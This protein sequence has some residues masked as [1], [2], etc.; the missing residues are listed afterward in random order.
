MVSSAV[1]PLLIAVCLVGC[2]SDASGDLGQAHEASMD[3][4]FKGCPPGIPSFEPGLQAKGN[5][6]AI[7]VLSAEPTEPQRYTNKWEVEL[8]ALDGAPAADA[9]IKKSQTF[10]PVHGHDG[11]VV[12]EVSALASAAQF[13]VDHL[14]FTMRGPWEVRFWLGGANVDEDYIVFHVC[15]AK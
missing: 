5:S 4:D 7:K 15:V 6:F 11:M 14:T 8:D 1:T 13:A 2:A 12:P 9:H 10:M 3:D